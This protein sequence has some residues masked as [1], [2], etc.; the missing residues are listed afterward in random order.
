[1]KHAV[2]MSFPWHKIGILQMVYMK[3]FDARSAVVIIPL[4]SEGIWVHVYKHVPYTGPSAPPNDNCVL[5]H[6]PFF[7]SIAFPH[8]VAWAF[9][10]TTAWS[11]NTTLVIHVH[12]SET[13]GTDV[14]FKH[15]HILTFQ[16]FDHRMKWTILFLLVPLVTGCSKK[17]LLLTH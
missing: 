3:Q 10:N 6:V 11:E 14:K 5:V 2:Y 15:S 7:S 4:T 13:R 8:T 1:L 9:G 17:K 16:M 12:A